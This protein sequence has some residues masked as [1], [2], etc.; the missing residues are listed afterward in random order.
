[1]NFYRE[2]KK[3]LVTLETYYQSR[4]IIQLYFWRLLTIIKIQQDCLHQINLFIIVMNTKLFKINLGQKYP[5][6]TIGQEL[7]AKLKIR[8]R[9]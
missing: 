2:T 5:I 8:I 1:M 4:F 7:T 9:F 6:R 3:S